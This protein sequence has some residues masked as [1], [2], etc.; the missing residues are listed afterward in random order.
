MPRL[1]APA[2]RDTRS[3]GVLRAHPSPGRLIK[4]NLVIGPGRPGPGRTGP[5]L[6]GRPSARG[7]LSRGP[8]HSAACF[9]TSAG[10]LRFFR[11]LIF[12]LPPGPLFP[13]AYFRTSAGSAF[14]GRLFSDFRRAPP[15]GLLPGG[16]PP[17]LE[18]GRGPRARDK[19]RATRASHGRFTAL[20][21]RSLASFGRSGGKRSIIKMFIMFK[22]YKNVFIKYKSKHSRR[23]LKG[24]SG[25][26]RPPGRAGP[27]RAGRHF[28]RGALSRGPL[29][30]AA[31]FRTPAGRL[32]ED[33]CRAAFRPRG[34]L[35]RSPLEEGR[36]P[37]AR[38]K[39]RG[40]RE[41]AGL[42]AVEFTLQSLC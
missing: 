16:L 3:Q 31:Y 14:F 11:P 1:A 37:R 39:R 29:R 7:A 21:S 4:Y 18:K 19:R 13:A 23:A 34:A 26:T 41:A 12:G 20:L 32:P 5:T 2:D 17:S 22:H 38:D 9:W 25:R 42:P 40:T 30:S 27:G 8:L 6:A 35:E 15:G 24:S 28:A 33:F 36:G 10:R